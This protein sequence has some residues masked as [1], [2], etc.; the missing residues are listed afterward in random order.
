M[1]AYQGL[2]IGI[3]MIVPAWYWWIPPTWDELKLITLIG[4]LTV[5][6][7][8]A[9]VHAYKVGEASALAPL[10]YIRLIFATLL[11]FL[12][13]GDLPDGQTIFGAA[14]IL[15]S[16]LYIMRREAKLKRHK[17]LPPDRQGSDINPSP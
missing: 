17:T 6:A 2:I 1:V 12:L 13:F 11:G 3:L 9:M 16:T 4:L 7:Q 15:A 5:F 10:D 8:W 14:I